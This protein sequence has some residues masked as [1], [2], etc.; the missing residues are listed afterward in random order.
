NHNILL[1]D[2]IETSPKQQVS[3]GKNLVKWGRIKPVLDMLDI[4]G[5]RVLDI[6]C[7]EGFFSTKISTMA[8][9]VMGADVDELRIKKA[10]FI[11]KVLKPKNLDFEIMDIYSPEFQEL[12]HFDLCICMGF[13]H[14]I[15]DPFRAVAAISS[16][17]D[18]VVFEWKSLKHG[19][20]DEPYAYFSQKSI[21]ND[22]YYGT[23]YWIVS[24]AALESVL[25]R[26]GF[27]HF[28]RVDDP[29]QRRAILVASKVGGDIFNQP[30]K[31]VHRG[32]IPALLSHTKRYV[33]TVFRIFSGHLNS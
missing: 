6:G 1:P 27:K 32:R 28:Y 19:L 21:D 33:K 22:D 9:Y 7:N 31:I 24:Y 2:G 16:I 17:S 8:S 29:R 25:K 10:R 18:T 23:E 14:R 26:L 3:H 15:P 4:T 20:H 13:L 30:D 12:E 11:Q 5:N